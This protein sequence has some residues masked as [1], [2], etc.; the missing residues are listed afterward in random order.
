MVGQVSGSDEL[1]VDSS[2][3]NIIIS[4]PLEKWRGSDPV[5]HPPRLCPLTLW[6]KGIVVVVVVVEAL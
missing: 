6:V 5:A 3:V 4:Y 1:S 2:P